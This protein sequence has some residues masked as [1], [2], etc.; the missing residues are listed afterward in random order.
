MYLQSIPIDRDNHEKIITIARNSGKFN[1]YEI[2]HLSDDLMDLW[3]GKCQNDLVWF[4]GKSFIWFGPD[5]FVDDVFIIHWILVDKEFQNKG[6]GK[7]LI[8]KAELNIKQKDGRLIIIETS[9]T[10][11]N[12]DVCNFYEKCGYIPCAIVPDYYKDGDSK[13]VYLKRVGYSN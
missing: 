12:R 13:V 4:D 6:I 10:N 1:Y 3:T 5:E 8:E 9:F 11:S 7:E 2:N